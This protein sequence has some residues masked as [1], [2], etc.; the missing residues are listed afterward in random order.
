MLATAS[1]DTFQ[2]LWSSAYSTQPIVQ[3]GIVTGQYIH[4]VKA[5]TSSINKTQLCGAPA[6]TIG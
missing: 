2:L 4:T 6:N 5:T 1:I 3:W